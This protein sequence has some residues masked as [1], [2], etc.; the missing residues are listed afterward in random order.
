METTSKVSHFLSHGVANFIK[1]NSITDFVMMMTYS[2]GFDW[3]F[4]AR[5]SKM[6]ANIKNDLK[7]SINWG[8]GQRY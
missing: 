2:T 1:K 7:K 3:N 5:L 8:R 6:T 4:E